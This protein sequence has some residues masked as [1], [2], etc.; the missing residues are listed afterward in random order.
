MTIKHFT[1]AQELAHTKTLINVTYCCHRLALPTPL[2]PTLFFAPP[3][4]DFDLVKLELPTKGMMV[5]RTRLS[6]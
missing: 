1:T 6:T 3:V 4:A 5:H 2:F